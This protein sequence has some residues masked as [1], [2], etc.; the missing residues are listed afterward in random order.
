MILGI[1]A[2]KRSPGVTTA[3]V[4][5]S[6]VWLG[7]RILL[8]ADPSGGDL[9]LRLRDPKGETLPTDG[10]VTSL[11][12]DAR[13]ALPAG[14]L[15]R[16][17]RQ[18]SLGFPVLVAPLSAE[19][20][21]PMAQLWQRI[22]T[23]ARLWPGTVISD[24]GRLQLRHATS[25]LAAVATAVVLLTRADTVEDLFHVRHRAHE[26][27]GR[28]GQ[29]PHGR[30]PL[31]VVVVAPA[32]SAHERVAQVQHALAAQASTSTIPVAGYLAEDRRAVETLRSGVLTKKLLG[33]DLLRSAQQLAAT[34]TAWFP[35]V[36]AEPTTAEPAV[37]RAHPPAAGSPRAGGPRRRVGE[38]VRAETPT[39]AAPG[40]ALR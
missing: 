8:E 13:E 12:A 32:R 28:L 30:S 9:V 24:L 39:N 31:T 35:E 29:G 11:A 3:A 4:A 7:E 1:C 22:A 34:L 33:S 5:L 14:A 27:A 16:Y 19:G 10:S 6:V 23:D 17:A 20:F 25:P 40:G 2:D 26:L 15:A 38:Q 18:S 37:N 21:E 36:V